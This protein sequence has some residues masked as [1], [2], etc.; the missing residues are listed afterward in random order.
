MHDALGR[1]DVLRE[2]DLA[3][4]VQAERPDRG[5][6]PIERVAR[7]RQQLPRRTN[8]A[9]VVRSFAEE[10][11]PMTARVQPGAH[12]V[13]LFGRR[14]DV[15]GRRQRDAADT[16]E[17]VGDD[18]RLELKLARIVDVAEQIAAAE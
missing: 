10:A 14:R 8:V 9:D 7:L 13:A 2:F 12:A 17:R 16:R 6:Q 4:T 11:K 15:D 1:A 5:A 18:L 3:Y